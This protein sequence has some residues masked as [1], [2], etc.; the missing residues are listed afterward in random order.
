MIM[1]PNHSLTTRIITQFSELEQMEADWRRLRNANPTAEI[2][3]AFNW[4]AAFWDAYGTGFELCTPVVYRNEVPVGI[5]PLFRD[6]RTIRFLGT[7]RSDYNDFLCDDPEPAV[8]IAEALNSLRDMTFPW[9]TAELDNLR[10]GSPFVSHFDE[11][12]D[13]CRYPV[14]LIESTVCPAIDLQDDGEAIVKKAAKKKSIKYALSKLRRMGDVVFRHIEDRDELHSYLDTFFRLHIARRAF[15]GEHSYIRDPRSRQYY[16]ALVERLDLEK[17]LRFSVLE[18]GGDPVAMHLGFQT[19]AKY[20]YYSPTFDLDW[21]DYSPGK[22]LL[23]KLL[24]HTIESGLREFDMALGDETY[25]ERFANVF[26]TNCR[27]TLYN[28]KLRGTTVRIARATK[29]RLKAHPRSF[30]VAKAA[31]TAVQGTTAQVSKIISHGGLWRAAAKTAGRLTRNRLFKHERVLVFCMSRETAL[32]LQP[33]TEQL[34]FERG[35]LGGLARL[36]ADYPDFF[37][38][39]RVSAGRERLKDGDEL[40]IVRRGNDLVHVAWTGIRDHLV[41]TE[42]G[43]K[44][45]IAFDE[46][47][48][49]VY[50]RWTPRRA[51]ARAI[52]H[53]V[54]RAFCRMAAERGFET[55]VCCPSTDAVS[56]H[57]IERAGLVLRC[58]FESLRFLHRFERSRVNECDP[59]SSGGALN[60]EQQELVAVSG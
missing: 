52:S 50:D 42:T 55:W 23:I 48:C 54:L 36:A 32:A 49:V 43:S 7:P 28:T 19:G 45:R 53:E 2:F 35:Y 29:V 37:T 11:V 16:R 4:N 15:I 57:E 1:T 30:A 21:W 10:Q 27:L 25:K 6:G 3:S 51:Q 9:T 60:R 17:E 34:T 5:L 58:Q 40:H 26:R 13:W 12:K 44:C 33:A 8:V 38:P 47:A 22:V 18:V 24:Q 41:A 56:R 39:A 14:S 59:Q 46:S 20:L 31:A